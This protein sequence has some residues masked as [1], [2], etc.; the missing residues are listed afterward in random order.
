MR[1]KNPSTYVLATFKPT[2]S[3]TKAV[4]QTVLPCDVSRQKE[5]LKN[6]RDQTAQIRRGLKPVTYRRE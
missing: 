6:A 1:N 2:M 3:L 4:F 5:Y